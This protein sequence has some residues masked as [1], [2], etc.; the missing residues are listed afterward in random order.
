MFI[1]QK[2][3]NQPPLKQGNSLYYKVGYKMIR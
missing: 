1:Q 2:E 3:K